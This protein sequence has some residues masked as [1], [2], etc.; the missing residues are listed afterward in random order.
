[1][2]TITKPSSYLNWT[3]GSSTKITQPPSAQQLSGWTEG[4][5]IPFQYLN[6]LF[7][8]TDQWIQW[9]DGYTNESQIDVENLGNARLINGGNW[10]WALGT[11]TFAWSSSFNIAIPSVPDTDNQVAAGNATLSDGQ[12]AYVAAN[13]PFT[14]TGNTNGASSNQL[15]NLAYVLGIVVGQT[16][17]GTNIPGGTTI[18]AV[19]VGA[20]SATM[21]A[22]AT[23][24]GSGINLTFSG[25]GALS[26]AVAT[27]STFVP[28]A[29]TI[30]IARRVGSIIYVGANSAQMILRDQESK[31]LLA[32]G[33]GVVQSATAGV[34]L[35]ANQAVYISQGN[36][37]GDI[38][39]TQGN[40][41]LADPSGPANAAGRSDFAGFVI[42]SAGS[43]TSANIVTTGIVGGFS[44][45]VQGA[46]YY[47]DPA[48]PGGITITRPT[49]PGYAEVNV[50]VAFS[51][52]QLLLIGGASKR[53][54]LNSWSLLTAGVNINANQAVYI[55]S[56]AG[57]D[58]ART[59][60]DIYLTDPGVTNGAVRSLCI[61]FAVLNVTSTNTVN[62]ASE[63]VLAGFSGLTPG[64]VYYLDPTTPG[65]ITSTKPAT[66]D[67]FIVP[68]GIAVSATQL[69]INPAL[70]AATI[71]TLTPLSTAGDILYVDTLGRPARLPIG[72]TGQGLQVSGGLPAWG[73]GTY[74]APT[75]SKAFST[76]IGT[77]GFAVS[78]SNYGYVFAITSASATAGSIYQ[79]ATTVTISNA[80]PGVITTGTVAHNLIPG[81]PVIFE[82]T[83][84]LPSPLTA[85]VTYYVS[86]VP[87]T[88]TFQVAYY[89]GGPSINTTTA[90]SGTQTLNYG[91]FTIGTTVSSQTSVPTNSPSLN[92][93]ATPTSISGQTPL[94]GTTLPIAPPV[95]GTLSLVSGTGSATL[96]FSNFQ[97]YNQ[98][99]AGT[100]FTVTPNTSA[101][102]VNDVYQDQKTVTITNASP[103]V[104]TTTVAHGL[105]IGQPITFSTTGTLPSPLVA[106]TT[107]YVSSDPLAT[108]FQVS[109][110]QYGA[111]INT[112]TAGSGTHTVNMASYTV[113][114]P[115]N[116]NTASLFTSQA[117]GYQPGVSGTLTRTSGTGPSSLTYSLGQALATYTVPT[118]PRQPLYIE[119]EL[120]GAGGGGCGANGSGTPTVGTA[121]TASVFGTSFIY[122]GGGGTA[123]TGGVGGILSSAT[124]W[125]GSA[126]IT[127]LVTV[128]GSQG[129]GASFMGGSGAST[130]GSAGGITPFGGAGMG[131]G[132]STPSAPALP[133]TGSGGGGA[134]TVSGTDDNG[135][136]GGAG[137]YIKFVINQS[138]LALTYLYAIGLGGIGGIT[139]ADGGPGAS[140]VLI[141]KESYQ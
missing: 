109:A 89:P 24:T 97:S 6:W 90:G 76:G 92:T 91:S 57:V 61:G 4:E 85:G 124:P 19:N 138:N 42:T 125:T 133:N 79:V 111:S 30:V 58:S 50:G 51:A 21:S 70:C 119:S 22:N 8:Q 59:A 69:W 105:I 115:A 14:T 96:V 83:G 55:S 140:G 35:T 63:G 44:G 36:A 116:A 126:S 117:T 128:P 122:A 101:F 82:T 132:P 43:S 93:N 127:P 39:R 88:T 18:T 80:S 15:T 135:P 113:L 100:L 72:S 87:T 67:Q 13:I 66:Q 99:Y 106:G 121:G 54:R 31:A 64:A 7:Y 75:I 10:S 137:A 48:N 108:T 134:G 114:G 118:S 56:G 27:S 130:P 49:L 33:F 37:N 53:A 47:L 102:V 60:G 71:N 40:L 12:I 23:G 32:Q 81:T 110:T 139:S 77:G 11:S 73:N 34:S 78:P 3:D 98:G 104:C 26:V 46:E 45:L 68:V 107:Y 25:T 52:T 2:G 95:S 74:N 16:V 141:I 41:Y 17:T 9:L 103:A 62:V 38:G 136:G 112:T 65:G 1:M 94:T 123:I 5:P 20:N 28:S 120:V 129:Q 131:G 29:N 84:A 86:V